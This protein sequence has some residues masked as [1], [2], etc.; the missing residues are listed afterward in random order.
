MVWAPLKLNS[1]LRHEPSLIGVT[2]STRSFEKV[3]PDKAEALLGTYRSVKSKSSELIRFVNLDPKRA[4]RLGIDGKA[5]ELSGIIDGA[6]LCNMQDMLREAVKDGKVSHVSSESISGLKRAET[7]SSDMALQLDGVLSQSKESDIGFAWLPFAVIGA[8]V[9][10]VVVL[11]RKPK[12]IIILKVPS[13][14]SG[15]RLSENGRS[16]VPTRHASEKESEKKAVIS[17]EENHQVEPLE[18]GRKPS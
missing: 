2:R 16:P 4:K 7:L 18:G 11:T 12:T 17:T 3:T 1:P 5:I 10:G 6:S 15:R 9:V 8:A 14:K 13:L